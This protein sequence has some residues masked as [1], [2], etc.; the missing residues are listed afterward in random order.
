M[1][2]AVVVRSRYED[3]FRR[4]L[5]WAS[6]APEAE[7]RELVECARG[8]RWTRITVRADWPSLRAELA[9]AGV[10]ETR[11]GAVTLGRD[12]FARA[13]VES[14]SFLWFDPDLAR[15]ELAD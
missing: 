7:L 12:P 15:D 11:D 14:A 2:N 13:F 5:E 6:H 8:R 10:L 9:T 3:G 1:T 4:G